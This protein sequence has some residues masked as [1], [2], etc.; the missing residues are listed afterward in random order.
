MDI[1]KNITLHMGLLGASISTTCLSTST[2]MASIFGFAVGTLSASD[3]YT[4]TKRRFI[5]PN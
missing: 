1:I 5:I 4:R 2:A 3:I